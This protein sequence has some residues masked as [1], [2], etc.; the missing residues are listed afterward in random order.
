MIDSYGAHSDKM[1]W[2]GIDPGVTTGWAL[3][4]DDGKVLGSGNLSEDEVRRG[5]DTL[6]RFAHNDGYA[7]RVVVERIPRSGI[8]H[9]SNRLSFVNG[10]VAELTD[11]VYDLSPIYVTPGEWKQSRVAKTTDLER[12][13]YTPHQRDA[14]RMTLYTMDRE[15]RRTHHA[16]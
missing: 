2:L 8:G 14:I 5:L 3:I 4:E 7:L 9:L 13:K 10:Q 12:G 6:I 11:E 1:A 15:S 16:K